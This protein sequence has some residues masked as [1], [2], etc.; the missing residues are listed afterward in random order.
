MHHRNDAFPRSLATGHDVPMSKIPGVPDGFLAWRTRPR[1]REAVAT[2]QVPAQDVYADLIK[3]TVSP[4]LRAAGLVGS[5]G[6]YSLKSDTHWALIGFQKSWYSDKNEV[7]FTV[8][9]LVVRR[10]D[11]ANRQAREP[12]LGAKPSPLIRY[13]PPA[14]SVRIGRLVDDHEDKW[15]RINSSQNIDLIEADLIDNIVDAGLPWLRE[16]IATT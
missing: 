9:L 16:Q 3:N 15:W 6:R 13:G 1:G 7:R 12:H 14:R 2:D 11:W 4:R 5:G 8:N 10:E